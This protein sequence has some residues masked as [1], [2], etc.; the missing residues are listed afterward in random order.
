MLAPIQVA[1]GK[2]LDG[3]CV[4]LVVEASLG[5]L[6]AIDGTV[7][8]VLG[9]SSEREQRQPPTVVSV[10]PRPMSLERPSHGRTRPHTMSPC[11]RIL[12]CHETACERRS[13]FSALGTNRA[14][15]VGQA[16]M[17]PSPPR[18]SPS[19]HPSRLRRPRAVQWRALPPRLFLLVRGP[20][21]SA[22][23]HPGCY[24]C[25]DMEQSF[26]HERWDKGQIGFHRDEVNPNL[27][28]H[29]QAWVPSASPDGQGGA[30]AQQRILV[31]LAG[32]TIDV[33]WLAARGADVVAAEFVEQAVRSYFVEAKLTPTEQR[34]D[35]GLRFNAKVP[36]EVASQPGGSVEFL[37]SD[38]F[39]LRPEHVGPLTLVYDRAALVA[40]S[41]ERRAEYAQQ[42][43]LLSPRGARLLLVSF[44]HDQGN[45][46]PFSVP[47]E[48]V[49]HLLS[50]FFELT[51]LADENI[52]E[53]EPRYKDRG[54]TYCH[55]HVW[56]GVRK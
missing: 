15:C 39:A 14:S 42:L 34:Y 32:K 17:I 30:L 48:D 56:L 4:S 24:Y 16:V 3:S 25:A 51:L 54:M 11:T 5:V 8:V 20:L 26:W 46:P 44:S 37:V 28:R 55:E 29:L 12:V 52:I 21:Q 13:D 45:G 36:G 33:T 22:R 49:R 1:G 19:G 18:Q 31:P 50:P 6:T 47:P 43:A 9:E 41:P 35:A 38:F 23:L 7:E 40:I 27:V 53:R 2:G 10:S